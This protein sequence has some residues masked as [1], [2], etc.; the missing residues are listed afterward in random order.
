[1]TPPRADRADD[2]T[3]PQAD[4]RPD[5]PRPDASRPRG[6]VLGPED[7]AGNGAGPATSRSAMQLG[8]DEETSERLARDRKFVWAL[9]R[10]LEI[11]R[12]FSVR[13]A[14]LGN[15]ELAEIT[16]LPKATITRLTHTLTELGYLRLIRR[17]GKY[18]PTAALLTLGYPVIS[19]LRV[20]LVAREPMLKLASDVDLSIALAARDRLGMIYVDACHPP[21]MTT[22]RLEVGTRVDI[23][24]T[25]LGRAFLAGIDPSERD[26]IFER[27][28]RKLGSAWPDLKARALD[29]IAEVEDRGFCIVDG[30][31]QSDIRAV[32]APVVSPDRSEV[33]ALNAAGPRFAASREALEQEVGPRLVHLSR[34]IGPMLSR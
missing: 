10:G 27:L 13:P 15:S 20:R 14:P 16:D 1:M 11:L 30:E 8:L 33:M 4:A 24:T 26:Y 28:S 19:S 18:E 21:T 34:A 3:Q 23:A 29:S 7:D 2:P 5:A 12:A 9:A 22:I 6:P 32:A 17:L 25:A 31:W